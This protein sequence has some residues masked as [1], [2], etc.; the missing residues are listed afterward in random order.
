MSEILKNLWGK[1]YAWAFPTA[2]VLGAYCLLVFPRTRAKLDWLEHASD[3][4]KGVIFAA[5]VA[6]VAFCLNAFS[7]ALYRILEGY[8]LWPGW[9]QRRGADT[10]RR[11]KKRLEDATSGASGWQRGLALEKLALY[12]Q[13]DEQIVPTRFGNALRSFETYGK[14]RFN[15]DS[16]TLWYELYA[17]APKYLQGE[18]KE[19]RS[20]VDFFV[21]LIY[22]NAALSLV[23]FATAALQR[24]DLA[25]LTVGIATLA[26]AFF[27]HWL[28]V[29]ATAEWGY[30]VQSLATEGFPLARP[31]RHH[32]HVC[33]DHRGHVSSRCG[34]AR[35]RARLGVAARPS[36]GHDRS[37]RRQRQADGALTLFL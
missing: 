18:I 32:L 2:L 35:R 15:L 17:G 20:S 9:L 5:A 31:P 14:T 28:A 8:L 13:R 11:R 12:P 19:A 22:L 7:T 4:E 6:V 1:L 25:I 3:T 26:M 21:A 23:C 27:C 36:P 34:E 29:R 16:Q 24:L 37:P 10:Q 33:G 30:T